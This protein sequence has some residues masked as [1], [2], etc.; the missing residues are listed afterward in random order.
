MC[1]EAG[2]RR[3]RWRKKNISVKTKLHAMMAQMDGQKCR[4]SKRPKRRGMS[5]KNRRKL[6]CAF[7][8][9]LLSLLTEWWRFCT[10]HFSAAQKYF[11]YFALRIFSAAF[12]MLSVF[13]AEEKFSTRKKRIESFIPIWRLY[14]RSNQISTEN[15]IDSIW[16][17][18]LIFR[19]GRCR[20]MC[21][22]STSSYIKIKNNNDNHG[23]L[24]EVIRPY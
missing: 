19:C 8:S 13:A 3:E 5:K 11:R 1:W 17:S 4:S 6:L 20:K 15:H 9:F 14:Q 21:I 16:R 18:I 7:R 23:S 10:N 12:F 22:T 24:F 2:S